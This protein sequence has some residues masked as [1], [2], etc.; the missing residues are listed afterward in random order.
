MLQGFSWVLLLA[1]APALADAERDGGPDAAVEA[2][3]APADAGV[4]AGIELKIAGSLRLA[5]TLV[6]RFP[7]DEQ[8]STAPNPFEVRARLDPELSYG[9]FR[10]A[11]EFDVVNGAAFGVPGPTIV[12]PRVP[13]PPASS[14][15]LRQAYL[16]YRWAT[17]AARLGQQTSQ[18]GL[19]ILSNAGATDAAPGDFGHS[20]FGSLVLRGLLIGRP[21][22]SLGGAWRAVEPLVAADLV[23]RD[24][25]ADLYQGDRA[26]QGIVGLRF[27]A[28]PDRIVALT[29]I[30]RRQ[31]A[32]NA[33]GGERA[34]DVLVIDLSAR[35]VFSSLTVGFELAAITG[36]T[37]QGRTNESPVMQVR[38]LGALGKIAWHRGSTSVLFDVG[39]A[40]GDNNPYDDQLNGFRF[41]RDFHAGL[42]LFEQVL[43]Y[44]TARSALRLADP[45]LVGAP[46][47]GLNLLP[48]GG[49]ITG[50][51]WLFP[52]VSQSLTDWLVLYGGPLVAFST[53][54]LSD[55]YS[56]RLLGGG[57]ALN[58]LGAKPG[59]YLGT[60]LDLGLQGRWDLTKDLRLAGTLEGG[61]FIPGNAFQRPTGTRMDPVGLVRL[62]LMVSL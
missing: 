9:K 12:A 37:T 18:F 2:E 31:R 30:Y 58:Y 13:V 24:G 1:A 27:N 22:F 45:A 36:S 60:E 50:A 29:A 23:V 14:L 33:P 25:T 42:I 17:G 51:V 11:V 44:Q 21:L 6:S 38:Q 43:G 5:Q 39:Y 15:E 59:D 62:R 47:E 20:R 35:W 41:D 28:A 7:I 49:A 3:A 61:A 10:L 19:G 55:P 54:K 16:E 8:I 40:S 32:D 57:A 56:S 52:R 53:A 48:T 34:T 46:P 26:V 4:P